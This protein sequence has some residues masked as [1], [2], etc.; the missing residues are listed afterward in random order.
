VE[1]ADTGVQKRKQIFHGKC[2]A[3]HGDASFRFYWFYSL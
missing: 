1:R 3:L 2:F